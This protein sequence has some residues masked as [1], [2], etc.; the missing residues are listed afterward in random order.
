MSWGAALGAAGSI[1]GGVA[2]PLITGGQNRRAATRQHE[3]NKEYW[4]LQNSY[5]HPTKQMQRLREA[6]LNP[7][8]IYGTP[9]GAAVG[10]A[11]KISPASLQRPA[12]M[13]DMGLPEAAGK[14]VQIKKTEQE[15]DNLNKLNTVMDSDKRLKD[16]QTL[17][18]LSQAGNTKY[19]TGR[20]SQLHKYQLDAA[21]A[22]VANSQSKT[23]VQQKTEE[24]QIKT[25]AAKLY[26]AQSDAEISRLAKEYK[27]IGIEPS[28][29]MIF[30]IMA[31]MGNDPQAMRKLKLFI[32]EITNIPAYN[33]FK[34]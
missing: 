34:N 7:N 28:D 27:E 14:Y 1:I 2:G 21:A 25:T 9:S 13:G 32:Q 26:K 17:N 20:E 15:T 4:N 24:D 3:R 5:N 11:D 31:R 16:A 29:N 10:N 23:R 8:L 19:K 22:D 30:R 12:P 6:G 18:Q 33:P